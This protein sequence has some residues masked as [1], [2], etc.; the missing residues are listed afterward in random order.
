[1]TSMTDHI[2]IA[3]SKFLSPAAPHPTQ[4]PS[5]PLPTSYLNRNR[6]YH[7]PCGQTAEART[8][9]LS[10]GCFG[11]ST[12]TNKVPFPAKCVFFHQRVP[13]TP[14]QV[15]LFRLG[16]PKGRKDRVGTWGC[17]FRTCSQDNGFRA[18][19]SS[20]LCRAA[21]E[22]QERQSNGH[23]HTM[24]RNNTFHFAAWQVSPLPLAVPPYSR[25]WPSL[26][27]TDSLYQR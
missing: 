26:S 6:F 17:G 8:S 15:V 18:A 2:N 19:C 11:N 16:W 23:R 24:C 25:E 5:S 22:T 4:S 21:S 20:G 12:H 7:P 14:A 10:F 9:Y 3:D 13:H 27:L 1:M